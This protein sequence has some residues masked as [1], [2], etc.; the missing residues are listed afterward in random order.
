MLRLKLRLFQVGSSRHNRATM[1]DALLKPIVQALSAVDP[2]DPARD[3]ETFDRL[4]VEGL[5][6]GKY[7]GEVRRLR[8]EI[9]SAVGGQHMYL[10]SGSLGSGKSTELRRLA[11]DLRGVGYHVSVLDISRYLNA[12]QPLKFADLLFGMAMGQLESMAGEFHWDATSSRIV[13]GLKSW[14]AAEVEF[15]SFDLKVIKG[16]LRQASVL[17]N[18]IRARFDTSPGEF[19]KEMQDFFVSQAGQTQTTRRLLIVDSLEHFHGRGGVDDEILASLRVLFEQHAGG[20][21]LPEWQVLYSVPPLLPKLAPGVIAIVSMAHI[22]QLTSAHVFKDRSTDPDIAM[23]PALQEMVDRRCGG[24]HNRRRFIDDALLRN[25]ILASGGDLR[26]LFRMLKLA[27]LYAFE[28]P[29]LPVDAAL[30][31][32]VYAN[33]RA[34]YL[35]LAVDTAERLAAVHATKQPLI[36][37]ENEWFVVMG[38]LAQKRM[39]LYRNGEVWYDVH[40][41][42]R[43]A[44]AAAAAKATE[45]A[46]AMAAMP[47]APSAASAA[48]STAPA[49]IAASLP[50]TRTGP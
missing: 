17:R 8:T 5:H 49:V 1:N 28:V 38:D 13:D 45:Q 40:P 31:D 19:L 39:L 14:F 16:D 43:D 34:P 27:A 41:L 9:E 4:Y 11:D 30:L 48:P 7:G 15:K 35:P 12:D 36:P 42:L 21:R 22:Y 44:V 20:M 3:R 23:L 46:A 18:Q 25:V 50:A 6:P 37:T 32:S 47:G 24:A 29:S 10:F 2:L 26:D 33:W